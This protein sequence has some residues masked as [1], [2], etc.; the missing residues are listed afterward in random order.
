M[1]KLPFR[2]QVEEYLADCAEVPGL[3]RRHHP[4]ATG[5]LKMIWHRTEQE[6]E[7][8]RR[9][10]DALTRAPAQG[11]VPGD[12]TAGD[13]RNGPEQLLTFGDD[14]DAAHSAA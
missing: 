1:S 5:A 13:R 6:A 7:Q 12:P 2:Q 9:A 4:T 11:A 3:D 10:F 8:I 14:S